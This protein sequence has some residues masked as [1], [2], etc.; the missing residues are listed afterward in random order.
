MGKY[1]HKVSG[2]FLHPEDDTVKNEPEG[3]DDL[4]DFF[5]FT[6]TPS[7]A[8]N[9]GS[10][11]YPNQLEPKVQQILAAN[12]IAKAGI[13][14]SKSFS[15]NR[16]TINTKTV[17]FDNATGIYNLAV[18]VTE[19]RIMEQQNGQ[20]PDQNEYNNILRAITNGD[21]FGSAVETNPTKG[22]KID[23]SDTVVVSEFRSKDSCMSLPYS[24]ND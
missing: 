16:M 3:Q 14:I 13:G 12:P 22:A 6:D 2:I 21:A 4:I 19:D 18:Y 8:V 15:E 11:T 23:S 24:K 10:D 17:F 9:A 1:E 20:T 5:G 7:S